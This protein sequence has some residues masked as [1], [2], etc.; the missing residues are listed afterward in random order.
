LARKNEF[1]TL[2]LMRRVANFEWCAEICAA[3]SQYP[4]LH[5]S[6][7][8]FGRRQDGLQEGREAAFVIGALKPSSN[9]VGVMLVTVAILGGKA[10]TP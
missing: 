8:T 2:Q 7:D 10:A 9:G 3:N 6:D 4:T 1:Q 5:S